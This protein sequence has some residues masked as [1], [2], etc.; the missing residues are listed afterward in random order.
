V[1]YRVE[2]DHKAARQIEA[3][4]SRAQQRV[5]AALEHLAAASG[6]MFQTQGPY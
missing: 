6:G 4:Q 3:L 2:V 1:R 5:I